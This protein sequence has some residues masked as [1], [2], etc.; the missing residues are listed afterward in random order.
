MNTPKAAGR[1]AVPPK[2]HDAKSSASG[3]QTG[4]DPYEVWRTRVLE[5]RA[6]TRAETN[7]KPFLVRST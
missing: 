5:S 3:G 1:V 4:G 6:N 7:P 2:A